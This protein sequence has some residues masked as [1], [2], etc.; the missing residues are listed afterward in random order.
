MAAEY[1]CLNVFLRRL[2]ATRDE[3]GV[4]CF[5]TVNEEKKMSISLSQ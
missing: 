3:V 1:N 4:C 2:R 5:K